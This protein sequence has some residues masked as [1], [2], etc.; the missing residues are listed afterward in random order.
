MR[1]YQKTSRKMCPFEEN[2]LE[3]PPFKKALTPFYTSDLFAWHRN[4][5]L[6]L[7]TALQKS[8]EIIRIIFL[9]SRWMSYYDA[10]RI[11]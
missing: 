6:G 11:S 1:L 7:H 9:G 8:L 4:V 3:L 5:F 2:Q 10:E